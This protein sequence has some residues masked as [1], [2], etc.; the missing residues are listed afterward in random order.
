MTNEEL[1]ISLQDGNKDALPVLWDQVQNFIYQRAWKFFQ[2]HSAACTR[3]GIESSDLSQLGFLAF[4]D[5]VMAY[6]PRSGYTFLTFLRYPL[7]NRFR[8]ALGIRTS[9]RF[10]LNESTSLDVPLMNE[11]NGDTFADVLPDAQAEEAF[12]EVEH[13][14]YLE[15]LHSDLECCLSTLPPDL[16]NVIRCRYYEGKTLDSI[17]QMQGRNREGVRQMEQ[18]GLQ[19][20]RMG[21]SLRILRRYHDDFISTHGYQGTG[22]TA[23]KRNGSV[24]ERITEKLNRF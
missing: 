9:K 14:A 1:A 4:M 3:A 16:E 11:E 22:F 12:R 10:P 15:R 23:W 19:K 18:K 13:K 2:L 6:K 5:A 8:E 20:L 17:A 24:E 21:A 7:K